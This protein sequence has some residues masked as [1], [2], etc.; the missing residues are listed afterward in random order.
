MKAIK[1]HGNEFAI[2]YQK[3]EGNNVAKIIPKIFNFA[4]TKEVKC[5]RGSKLPTVANFFM[6]FA[7]KFY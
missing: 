4:T 5:Y 3:S 1:S 7:K 6:F 2:K